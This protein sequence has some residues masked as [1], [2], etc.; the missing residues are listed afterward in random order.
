MATENENETPP[1]T[2]DAPAANP[3]EALKAQAL[4]F[5][6]RARQ[7]GKDPVVTLQ[8]VLEEIADK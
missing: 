5:I 6:I 2:E 3:Y 7:L 1:D 8:E 4:A